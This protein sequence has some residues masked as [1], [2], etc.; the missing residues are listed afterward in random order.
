MAAQPSTVPS[1]AS[2]TLATTGSPAAAPL[3]T[4][5]TTDVL[6]SGF[7]L[8]SARVT[9]PDGTVCD[10]CL[11]LAETGVQRSRGLMSVT[12]LGPADGMAFVYPQPHVTRFW[13]KDTVLPLS[14]AFYDPA[15]KF[16]ESF[17]MEPC[18]TDSCPTYP[19]PIGFLI[20]VE[21][22]QGALAPVGMVE[23]STLEVLDRPC[24]T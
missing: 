22:Y 10:L 23:G 4:I 19:T 14:I 3:T 2:S 24:G 15:G 11:W 21:A 16:M 20:A 18:L 8:V 1:S 9:E 13:M 5:D 6:P 12:D 17:D 7:D